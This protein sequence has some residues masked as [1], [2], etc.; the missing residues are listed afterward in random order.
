MK[1]ANS[2]NKN[3][4]RIPTRFDDIMKDIQSEKIK[5]YFDPKPPE[6]KQGSYIIGNV[7]GKILDKVV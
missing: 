1:I 7:F 3:M 4:G 5:K 6:I 2:I